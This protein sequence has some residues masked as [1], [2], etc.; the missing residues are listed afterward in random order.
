MDKAI[1]A[2]LEEKLTTAEKKSD[3]LTVE[4]RHFEVALSKVSPS[5]SEKVQLN[6]LN[7]FHE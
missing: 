4:S 5:V 3:T 1:L 2:A 7:F 6:L